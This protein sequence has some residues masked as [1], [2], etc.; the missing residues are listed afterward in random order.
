M[1]FCGTVFRGVTCVHQ[2]PGSIFSH[3]SYNS[4]Q[5]ILVLSGWN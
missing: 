3:Y 4:S 5:D 1:P 2:K